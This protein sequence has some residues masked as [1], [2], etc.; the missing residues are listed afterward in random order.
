K[1]QQLVI[2]AGPR[3]RGRDG[4]RHADGLSI[5]LAVSGHRVLIDP[6]TC[7][8]VGPR[9]ERDRFRGTASHNT[10]HV[11][12]LSQAEPG[13]PF[14]W[15]GLSPADINRWVNG[16]TFDFFEGSH[17]G[18]GRLTDPVQHR[19]S[20]FYWKPHFWFVRDVVEGAGEHQISLNWHFADGALTPI[21]GG[22]TFGADRQGELNLPFA[23]GPPLS[24]EISPDWYSPVYGKKEPAMLLRCTTATVLPVELVSLLVPVSA[25]PAG[26]GVLKPLAA[27]RGSASA[28]AYQYFADG[29]TDYFFV[30]ANGSGDWRVG[31]WSSDA[32]LLFCASSYQ[33]EPD[34]FVIC[35]GSYLALNGRRLLASA[36]NLKYA[37]FYND[38]HGQRFH[39]SRADAV[40]IDPLTETAAK[41][42]ISRAPSRSLTAL[43]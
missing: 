5:H 16:N 40:G 35:D 14:E 25:R 38:A 18:Y 43:P 10:I 21:P 23:S 30:C 37:E 11:D 1:G 24:H 13:G 15:R 32:K 7:V 39:C 42:I 3:E 6:G 36:E 31:P 9:G 27:D 8:Y 29:T 2:N 22:V 28:R 12:G 41:R 33:D 4:H 19:R 20:I 26:V 34:A 17:H